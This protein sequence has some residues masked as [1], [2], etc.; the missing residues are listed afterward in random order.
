MWRDSHPLPARRVAEVPPIHR[1]ASNDCQVAPARF[2]QHDAAHPTTNHLRSSWAALLLLG[3][4]LAC[5]S[6]STSDESDDTEKS[7]EAP[8]DNAPS[9]TPKVRATL[10]LVDA[11]TNGVSRT[12]AEL[13][14]STTPTSTLDLGTYQGSCQDH[15]ADPPQQHLVKVSCWYAGAG[16]DVYVDHLG[17]ELV[18]SHLEYGEEETALPPPTVTA[19]Y[20]IQEGVRVVRSSAPVGIGNPTPKSCNGVLAS[21]C[22][23]P[24]GG[25]GTATCTSGEWS[26]CECQ[27]QTQPGRL[28][29]KHPC[30]VTD[31]KGTYNRWC[32]ITPQPDGSLSI[33]AGGTQLNPNT[34]LVATATGGPARYDIDG[35]LAWF[36]C[37]TD[38]M[39]METTPFR[40]VLADQTSQYV[41]TVRRRCDTVTIT[42][43]A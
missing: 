40:S 10:R 41:F 8:A 7:R 32:T 25:R 33:T 2:A 5:R 36:K 4:L 6:S 3:A 29:G 14:L 39:H 21:E 37:H 20:R 9:T 27:P 16:D 1:P 24:G 23:C 31:G 28:L 43:R 15:S 19:R 35:S 13:E 22:E 12:K 38:G 11:T 17:D 26:P 42:I 30:S 18:V 34:R